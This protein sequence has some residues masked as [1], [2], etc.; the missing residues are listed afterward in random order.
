MDR[1]AQITDSFPAVSLT[2]FRPP[3]EGEGHPGREQP[4]TAQDAKRLDDIM[5]TLLPASCGWP[6]QGGPVRRSFGACFWPNGPL[7]VIVTQAGVAIQD[8]GAGISFGFRAN[9]PV[10]AASSLP[11][12]WTPCWSEN[13]ISVRLCAFLPSVPRR[14]SRHSIASIRFEK[15]IS[16]QR[17]PRKDSRTSGAFRALSASAEFLRRGVCLL[18]LKDPA[19]ALR[20]LRGAL[21]ALILARRSRQ[22]SPECSYHHPKRPEP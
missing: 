3:L 10:S 4:P 7:G 19:L 11:P 17:D 2:E 15:G 1:P 6:A 12:Y 13:P 22:R 8:Y 21:R 16:N 14:D 20:A 18:R 9:I 5:G